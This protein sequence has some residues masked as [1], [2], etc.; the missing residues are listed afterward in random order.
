M[1]SSCGDFRVS[2]ADAPRAVVV[3]V[4]GELDTDTASG[5]AAH[6][7]QMAEDSGPVILGMTGVTFCD[8]SGL[9]ALL[10]AVTRGVDVRIVGSRRVL[11]VLD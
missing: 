11:K 8:S 1:A 5:L 4:S 2:V 10:G 7:D 6:L 9:N 3:T